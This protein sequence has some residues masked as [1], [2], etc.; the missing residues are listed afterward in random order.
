MDKLTLQRI[1]GRANVQRLQP[2]A[3]DA[4]N[5]GI[6]VGP[7]DPAVDR[8]SWNARHLRLFQS[9]RYDEASSAA[10]SQLADEVA[11]VG[12]P[13]RIRDRV[14]AWEDSPATCLML[15]VRGQFEVSGFG[16]QKSP[17]LGMSFQ[18]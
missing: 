3:N 17:P 8:D 15:S 9:G 13:A 11:L 2:N 16:H 7:F 12:T 4:K 6:G 1:K 5:Q 18:F 10:P 14:M